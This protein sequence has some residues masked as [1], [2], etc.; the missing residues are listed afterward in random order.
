L[1]SKN[2]LNTGT[3][4]LE[5]EELQGVSGMKALRVDINLNETA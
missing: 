5:L 1:Q 2:I 3:E 4:N